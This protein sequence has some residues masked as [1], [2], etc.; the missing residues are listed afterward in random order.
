MLFILIIS[1]VP[2]LV[3][4]T[5]PIIFM[6][7][8]GGYNPSFLLPYGFS[9]INTI[10]LLAMPLFI[11]AGT[12]MEHSGIAEKLINAGNKVFGRM[13]GGLAILAVLASGVFASVSG[14]ALATTACIGGIMGPR[15]I[16]AGYPRGTVASLLAASGVIG[17]LIPPSCLMIL[18][19]WMA[20]VSVLKCFLA[21]VIPGFMIV[22][23]LCLV[24]IIMLRNNKNI[25]VYS[26]SELNVKRPKYTVDGKKEHGVIWALFMPIIMLG[27]IYGGI[28]TPTEAAAVSC[29][30]AIPIGFF[31]Y[32]TLNWDRL[33]T[34]IY[35]AGITIGV[36]MVCSFG[37]IILGRI[38]IN[39]NIHLTIIDALFKIST[40]PRVQMLMINLIVI[41]LG[42]LMDD[43]CSMLL[44]IPILA[45]VVSSIGFDLIHF[46]AIIGVNL[47]MANTTPPAAPVLYLASRMTGAPVEEM[48]KPTGIY[49]STV[50]IPVLLLVSYF[51]ELATWLPNLIVR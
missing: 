4:F 11:I 20:N 1:G 17:I 26:K 6:V 27:G 15:M 34:T 38:F 29:F 7:W 2:I 49:I 47:G 41:I 16:K 10:V 30:Y 19:A 36:I 40:N 37:S 9:R 22:I 32:K 44:A 50:F 48:L 5:A 35:N 14:S 31:I 21:T 45:P 43:D 28:F 39:E 3:A 8:Q 42:M 46:S 18:Y 25:E 24:S 33:R 12:I 23:G 51:P 13:R